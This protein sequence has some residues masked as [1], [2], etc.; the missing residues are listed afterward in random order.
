M[1]DWI[2][3]L[4]AQLGGPGAGLAI[5]LESVFPPIP[6]E[7]VLPL[8]G[9]AAS[10]GDLTLAG[11]IAWTT[12]GSLVGAMVLYAVGRRLGRQ[13]TRRLA[14]KLPLIE[15]AD[16]D[17]TEAWFARHGSKAVFFGRMVPLFRSLVSIP[18]GI[19]EMPLAR[20]AALTAAGS[21]IWN[22]ALILGGYLLGEQWHEV[23]RYTG[24]I[25][26]VVLVA[27]AAGLV[28]FVIGRLRRRRSSQSQSPSR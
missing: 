22:S 6:S 19:E 21:L 3:R 20:F 2:V 11:A 28:W 26:P 7:L 16:L 27:C 9:F 17:K 5:A 14:A 13:R 8:A 18:A 4:M 1:T 25:Q 24:I 23:R 12:V 10:R 15:L